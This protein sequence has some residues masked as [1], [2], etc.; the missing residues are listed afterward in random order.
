MSYIANKEKP[1][2][3]KDND[4][5]IRISSVNFIALFFK[6]YFIIEDDKNRS[7]IVNTPFLPQLLIGA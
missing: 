4:E 5:K 2:N 7:Q 6:Y 3:V 1:I